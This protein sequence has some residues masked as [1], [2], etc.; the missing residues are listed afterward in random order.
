MVFQSYEYLNQKDQHSNTGTIATCIGTVV[1]FRSSNETFVARVSRVVRSKDDD[2]VFWLGLQ[3]RRRSNIEWVKSTDPNLSYVPQSAPD[4]SSSSLID[5]YDSTK[6][7]LTVG[8]R[9]WATY[10]VFENEAREF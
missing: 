3:S 6:V 2:K 7:K 9:V 5:V 10:V 8:D 1:T 4:L